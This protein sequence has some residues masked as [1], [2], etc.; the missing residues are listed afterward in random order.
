[1][2]ASLARARLQG[3]DLRGANLHGADMARVRRDGT[4]QLDQALLTKVRVHPRHVE[5]KV[6]KEPRR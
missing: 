6:P 2:G 5:P 1:M 4:L 3:V